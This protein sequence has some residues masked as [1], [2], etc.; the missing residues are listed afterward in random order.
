MAK[1]YRTV[2]F[3]LLL[4]IPLYS[5]SGHFIG[6]NEPAST[7]IGGRFADTLLKNKTINSIPAFPGAEGHGAESIGG[8]GGIVVKVTNLNWYYRFAKPN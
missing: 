7:L 6:P 2:A 5:E 3:S 4:T 1:F 8:R